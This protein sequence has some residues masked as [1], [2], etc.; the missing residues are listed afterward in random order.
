MS[1][2]FLYIRAVEKT[3]GSNTSADLASSIGV[4]SKLT[5]EEQ[6]QL[7]Q[8]YIMSMH[9]IKNVNVHVHIQL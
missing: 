2:S 4:K 1:R 6:E 7:N 3:K 5:Q 8:L 9:Y